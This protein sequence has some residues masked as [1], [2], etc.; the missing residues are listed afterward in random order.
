MLYNSR[1]RLDVAIISFYLILN[2][3]NNSSEI[4]HGDKLIDIVFGSF[5]TKCAKA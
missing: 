1:V 2:I 3:L 4:V 5:S